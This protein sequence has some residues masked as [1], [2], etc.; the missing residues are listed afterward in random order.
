[1]N[2]VIKSLV[3][4]VSDNCSVGMEKGKKAGSCSFSCFL[5][6]A[7]IIFYFAF[8][9]QND[10]CHKQQNIFSK[11]EDLIL[12]ISAGTRILASSWRV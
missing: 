5:L 1:M 9:N 7:C 4:N 8:E 12:K 11:L 3:G 10:G 6:S 2:L